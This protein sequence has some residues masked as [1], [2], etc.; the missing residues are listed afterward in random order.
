ME[1]KLEAEDIVDIQEEQKSRKSRNR[2]IA[3][4]MLCVMIAVAMYALGYAEGYRD[5]LKD[6]GIIAYNVIS[7]RV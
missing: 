1:V 6:F 3:A 4:L 5:A 7:Y 2:M